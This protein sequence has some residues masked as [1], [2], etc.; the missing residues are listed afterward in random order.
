MQIIK[1]SNERRIVNELQSKYGAVYVQTWTNPAAASATAV[2]AATNL[3]VA[4]QTITANLTNPDFPRNITIT[5]GFAGQNGV[6]TINGTNIRGA[7]ITENITSNG[8]ATV[9]GNKAFKTVTSIVLPAY[10]NDAND[11]ISVGI[12]VKLGLERMLPADLVLGTE[13][14]GTWEATRPTV[15]T[16]TSAIESNTASTNT[17]P[18]GSKPI[19]MAYI[20]KELTTSKRVTS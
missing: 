11:T 18:N 14:N 1:T 19:V 2:L 5:G 17:A 9:V 3:A 6:V 20:T 7:T 12:G 16:S 8:T 4:A 15:A 10:T 13:V